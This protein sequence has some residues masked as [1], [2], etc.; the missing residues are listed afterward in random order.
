MATTS[1]LAVLRQAA[2]VGPQGR[3]PEVQVAQAVDRRAEPVEAWLA[4]AWA[5]ERAAAAVEA[6]RTVPKA[7]AEVVAPS[8][9]GVRVPFRVHALAAAPP[10]RLEA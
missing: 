5:V 2:A 6:Q 8:F 4:E 3:L 10:G 9:V 7:V 1:G